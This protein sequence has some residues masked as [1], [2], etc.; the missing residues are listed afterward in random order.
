MQ[1][2]DTGESGEAYDI[3][4][5]TLPRSRLHYL[6]ILT[7]PL[8]ALPNRT[9]DSESG[10]AYEAEVQASQRNE[11]E[12]GMPRIAVSNSAPSLSLR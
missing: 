8:S 7:R 10:E 2:S 4:V 1:Y 3:D 9:D 6:T 11:S 12:E 5:Q